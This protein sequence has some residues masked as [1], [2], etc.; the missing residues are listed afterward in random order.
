MEYDY[1][2][3]LF[4]KKLCSKLQVSESFLSLLYNLFGA[5]LLQRNF[6]ILDIGKYFCENLGLSSDTSICGTFSDPS[7]NSLKFWFATLQQN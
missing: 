5:S 3:F 7:N 1:L 2:W 4:S 6:Q